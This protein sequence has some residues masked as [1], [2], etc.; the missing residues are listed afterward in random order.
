[1]RVSLETEYTSRNMQTKSHPEASGVFSISSLVKI[2]ILS[3]ISSLSLK[4][5]LNSQ[6]YYR[7]ISGSTS[8]VL[9]NLRNL[10]TFSENVR[11]IFGQVLKNLLKSSENRSNSVISMSPVRY[12]SCHSNIKVISSRHCVTTF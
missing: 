1:M 7:N 2:S 12:F 3:Q 11:V 6:V 4:V 5:Y 8:K 9:G 10:R